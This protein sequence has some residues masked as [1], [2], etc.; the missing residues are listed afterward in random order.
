ML[1]STSMVMM[2]TA[3]MTC[4]FLCKLG[5]EGMLRERSPPGFSFL[6]DILLD[7]YGN[8]RS[9]CADLQQRMITGMNWDRESLAVLAEIKV[10]TTG[11]WV[12]ALVSDT[13]DGLATSNSVTDSTMTDIHRMTTEEDAM[14]IGGTTGTAIQHICL[15]RN[16]DKVVGWVLFLSS[17][18][19][20][21]LA[22]IKVWAFQALEAEAIDATVAEIAG[23]VVG[24]KRSMSL[25][26]GGC[27]V[28][29]RRRRLFAH[30]PNV[31]EDLSWS[32]EGNELVTFT[33]SSNGF[34]VLCLLVDHASVAVVK[35]GAVEALVANTDDW[36]HVTTIA[37]H[38]LV[39][40]W[41]RLWP[42]PSI[43]RSIGRRVIA[44]AT[45]STG[46]KGRSHRRSWNGRKDVIE[47]SRMDGC[48]VFLGCAAEAEVVVWALVA[49]IAK[50]TYVLTT[51]V[52]PNIWMKSLLII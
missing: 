28:G 2:M 49:F 7:D 6:L 12:H 24:S 17:S 5:E 51:F 18:F 30:G 26:S 15:R 1:A 4:N 10:G 34:V 22:D 21:R 45:S 43:A 50:A 19:I 47:C 37:R 3:M 29:T 35:V 16:P 8:L 13:S 39:L 33:S 48:C 46:S 11:R 41:R 14:C 36:V 52:A 27:R 44:S 23:C 20:A 32:V 40:S 31:D 25:S 42:F 38:A 9:W